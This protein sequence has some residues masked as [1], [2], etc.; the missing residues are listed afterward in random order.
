MRGSLLRFCDSWRHRC[1][2]S[3]KRQF[4]SSILAF[5]HRRGRFETNGQVLPS[6]ERKGRRSL[7]G[8]KP[9]FLYKTAGLV[10]ISCMHRV[11]ARLGCIMMGK[12]TGLRAVQS[13]KA[14]RT[15]SSSI[16]EHL[17]TSG[18]LEPDHHMPH[19]RP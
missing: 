6:A 4:L 9:C 10:P 7:G 3:S 19:P 13:L 15:R 1:R 8:G 14:G 5:G 18:A 2:W 11:E 12:Q 17:D 16:D